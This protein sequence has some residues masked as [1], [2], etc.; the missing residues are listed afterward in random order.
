VQVK[1]PGGWR[2]AA[3][4]CVA[5]LTAVVL[6]LTLLGLM[7]GQ[8]GDAA[9][10]TG[11]A[12]A[13]TG[14]TASASPSTSPIL[15]SG[16][17][18]APVGASAPLPATSALQA[19]LG[20]LLAQSG[21]GPR[22]GA[23][24]LDLSTGRLLFGHDAAVGFSTAST[25]KLLT[26]TAALQV[27]GPD[28]RIRTT[29]VAG[30]APGQVV[31]V[32]GGDPTLATAAPAGFVPAPA[33]LRDLARATAAA[34]RTHGSR[35]VRLGYDSSLFSGPATAATWPAS[36]LSSGE[37]AP[38][39]AL[40]VDEGRVGLI[41]EGPAPR[42]ADPALGAARAFARQ[43]GLAGIT[44]TGA[45]VRTTAPG[46]TPGSAAGSSPG[47][48]GS[49]AGSP[50]ATATSSGPAP[51]GTVLAS[52]SSPTLSDLLG[53][54]LST[55]DNDLAEAVAHLVARAEGQPADFPG[56]VTAVTEALGRLRV[57][58]EQ[59]RMYDGSGLSPQTEVEPQ[60][61]GDVLVLAASPEHAALRPLLTGLA[62]AGFTGSLQPPRFDLPATTSASGLVRA[63]TGTLTGVA[64]I[65]GTVEDSSG[66]MLAFV[67]VA[68]RVPAA[69]TLGA[70]V[71]LDRLAAAVASC[72]CG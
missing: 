23:A 16:D 32:G 35:S 4:G 27:L 34:L 57:P 40:S 63:K 26:A 56:G 70:R 6:V 21:L 17:V 51:P 30:Q 44:V 50:S 53:W 54:M 8:G 58:T 20:P 67:F 43:L 18:L 45:P 3:L 13:T 66:R 36:Y 10:G 37:V 62:V 22:V 19:V 38:A 59:L 29:V 41:A 60:V 55:S 52:V 72:G 61:L 1:V 65:A 12:S 28:Y 14:R 25:T 71:A 47:S 5:V 31:L 68:D 39:A 24:V 15:P 49:P 42:V 7:P 64:A 11:S 48:S 2:A 69:G 46:S 33:S 9:H